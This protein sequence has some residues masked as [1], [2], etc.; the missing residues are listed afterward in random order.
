[1]N[2]GGSTPNQVVGV[3]AMGQQEA[4]RSE[5]PCT[6]SDHEWQVVIQREPPNH[7]LGGSGIGGKK[8]EEKTLAAGRRRAQPQMRRSHVPIQPHSEPCA[9]KASGI[10]TPIAFAVLRLTTSSPTR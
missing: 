7:V 8:G 5:A 4:L 2:I 9:R 6:P 1:V 3:R 10:V